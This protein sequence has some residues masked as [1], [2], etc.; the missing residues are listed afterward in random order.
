MV[1]PSDISEIILEKKKNPNYVINGYIEIPKIEDEKNVNIP[2]V[3]FNEKNE[4][5]YMSRK[6]IP[7]FKDCARKPKTYFKQVCIYAFSKNDLVKFS[8]YRGK[9]LIESYEDIE[10][11]RFLELDIKIKMVKT[12]HL[13]Y[14][15]DSPEDLKKVEKILSKKLSEY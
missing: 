3:I 6:D 9:S 7:G 15:I 4:L 2:K 12:N 10:I 8:N 11:L 14:G 1:N 13:S 5:I